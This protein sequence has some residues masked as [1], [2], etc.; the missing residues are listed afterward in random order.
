MGL[1]RSLSSPNG[2][3]H[4]P[5]RHEPERVADQDPETTRTHAWMSKDQRATGV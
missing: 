1:S 3:A 5:Q 4:E 2:G